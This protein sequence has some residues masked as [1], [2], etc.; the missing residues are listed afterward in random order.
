MEERKPVAKRVIMHVDLDAFFTAC[1]EVRR[2][3]LKGKPLVVCVYSGRTKDSGAVSTANYIAR[4]YGVKAGMP[5]IQAKKLLAN[6]EAEFL[7]IDKEYYKIVSDRIMDILR[8]VAD[9]F[10]QVS[11]DEAYLDI[12]NRTNG[13]FEEAEVIAKIL[14]KKIYENEGITCSIG[15]GPNKVVAKIA[16]EHNKPDGL[17]VVK[18]EEVRGFLSPL[19]VDRLVG[20]GPKTSEKLKEIGIETL[21]Q[22]AS[23]DVSKLIGIFGE[24]LGIYFHNSAKGIDDEPVKQT[25]E[26]E[27]SRIITLRSNTR[28]LSEINDQVERAIID[29]YS[30]VRKKGCG[31]KMVG[32]IAI[33]DKLT[34][35]VRSKKL[36][37][38]AYDIDTIKKASRELFERLLQ[39]E[40]NV[41]LRRA[42]IKVSGL[43]K[44]VDQAYIDKF[45]KPD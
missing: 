25:E 21:G 42:G 31:Y 45:I 34:M 10:E 38:I 8:D 15:I 5:I 3:E 23:T 40:P 37:W 35:L 22:L 27:L 43:V 41:I 18:P 17:T 33:S 7:P 28:D 19:S 16:S 36:S 13:S 30:R 26:K 32:I 14:K 20:I 29:L 6:I 12:T 11:I 44:S 9:A 39:E 24:K 4:K 2:P 1:E